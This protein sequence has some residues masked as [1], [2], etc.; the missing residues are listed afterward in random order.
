[1]TPL[2]LAVKQNHYNLTR[3]LVAEAKAEV[4]LQASEKVSGVYYYKHPVEPH[5]HIVC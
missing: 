4:N 1:M 3:Y 2:I 5:S